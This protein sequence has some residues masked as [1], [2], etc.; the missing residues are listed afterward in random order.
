M[1]KRSELA[2]A[3]PEPLL[4]Q[5]GP[6]KWSFGSALTF[7]TFRLEPD[8]TLRR[9]GAL[10]HLPPKESG[11]LQLLIARAGQ[12]VSLLELQQ[13]LWGDVHVTAESIPKCLS[14]LRSRLGP[15][16]YIQ[17]VYK[18]GYRFSAQVHQRTAAAVAL[19]P[20]LAIMPFATGYSIPEHMGAAIAE[21]TATGLTSLPIP[22][23]SVLARDSVFNLARRGL[24]AQQIGEMLK[25]NFV[26]AG[27]LR[28][29]PSHIRLRAEMVRVEDGA[30]IWVEDVLVPLERV[31]GL[32]DELVER[33]L[34]RLSSGL[35]GNATP[36]NFAAGSSP[37]ITN[38]QTSIQAAADPA[39][40]GQATRFEANVPAQ[41]GDRGAKREAYDLFHRAHYEWQSLQRHRMQD[42]LQHLYRA[43]EL[44]PSLVSGR[45][46]LV[47]LCITQAFYGFMSPASAIDHARRAVEPWFPDSGPTAWGDLS[48][49]SLPQQAESIFPALGW[50]SLHV[51]H[52]L[53]SAVKA[54]ARSAHLPHDPW[55]SRSRAMFAL[56]LHRFDE[57]VELLR[58]AIRLD[59]FS[60]WL[61]ARLAWALHLAGKQAESVASIRET[62]NTFPE[63]E[64]ANLYGSMILA[65]NGDVERG[66][67]LA[68]DLTQRLPYFDLA[69]V[70]HAYTLAC[71]GEIEEARGIME[72]LQW[73]SRERFVLSSFSP[74]AYVALGEFDAAIGELR[75]AEQSGCPW[76][77]QMLAD[78]RL[79]PLAG[80]PEFQSLQGI[81]ARME[82]EAGIE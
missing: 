57:A 12:T 58:G 68:A 22:L 36:M 70:V 19:L 27:T 72:R 2:E 37:E 6:T 21:E 67:K 34:F 75:A 23:V 48:T 46:D 43:I 1:K 55:I 14:S 8:G 25:A 10:I 59:P 65:F 29:L 15:E 73:M 45:M 71:A 44:D 47:N 82:D 33:L 79:A 64:G 26:L 63:H 7:G 28:A 61:H 20:R 39:W 76:F 49:A 74:A 54:F 24:A 78:P 77:F 35:P 53:T 50:I 69:T 32:E 62:L 16:G 60:P 30:Q 66:V 17:T 9:N 56:S 5:P 38:W 42:S 11:A 18:R 13:A 40:E 41:A 51:N 31:A 80:R 81:L 52:D 4:S 3:A